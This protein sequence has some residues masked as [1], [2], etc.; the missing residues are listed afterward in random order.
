MVGGSRGLGSRFGG[1]STLDLFGTRGWAISTINQHT[2]RRVASKASNLQLAV[3]GVSACIGV[4][5]DGAR[6]NPKFSVC[7]QLCSDLR[8]IYDHIENLNDDGKGQAFAPLLPPLRRFLEE[9]DQQLLAQALTDPKLQGARQRHVLETIKARAFVGLQHSNYKGDVASP[10]RFTAEGPPL[11]PLQ[12]PRAGRRFHWN[13]AVPRIPETIQLEG[14]RER[15]VQNIEPGGTFNHIVATVC[16]RID[17]LEPRHGLGR[18][19]AEMVT[20]CVQHL[21]DAPALNTLDCVTRVR[22]HQ[23]LRVLANALQYPK[24]VEVAIFTEA[25]MMPRGVFVGVKPERLGKA[26]LTPEPAGT[27]LVGARLRKQPEF[28]VSMCEA[29]KPDAEKVS[30]P[31]HSR[32]SRR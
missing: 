8:L 24:L 6:K 2:T 23:T 7:N 31:P 14:L 25:A 20:R 10:A 3:E 9:R 22:L 16:D 21:M 29:G 28:F 32:Q 26:L 12:A 17:E 4:M 13:T 11:T 15:L 19:D 30:T 27:F 1:L 5:T 18:A